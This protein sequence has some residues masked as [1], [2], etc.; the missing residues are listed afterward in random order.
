MLYDYA[1]EE[2]RKAKSPDNVELKEADEPPPPK[3][4]RTFKY[5]DGI[6]RLSNMELPFL[7]DLPNGSC[8]GVFLIAAKNASCGLVPVLE[9]CNGRR[10][11]LDRDGGNGVFLASH[12]A[13]M[14]ALIYKTVECMPEILNNSVF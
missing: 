3:L 1:E 7:V 2:L 13:T 6:E 12:D 9:W 5:V 10:T 4:L 11:V 8:E 14:K